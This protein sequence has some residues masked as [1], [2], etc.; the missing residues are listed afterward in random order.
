MKDYKNE[1]PR[2]S[3]IQDKSLGNYFIVD[4]GICYTVYVVEAYDPNEKRGRV[5]RTKK[6]RTK[7][8]K[9]LTYHQNASGALEYVARKLLHDHKKN[10]TLKEYA[11]TYKDIKNEILNI[12][13]YI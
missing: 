10:Y 7:N 1:F 13:L 2:N 12:E 6:K 11:N 5:F 4:D 8:P 3:L 9:A